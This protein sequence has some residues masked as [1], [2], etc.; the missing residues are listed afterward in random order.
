MVAEEE[1]ESNKSSKKDLTLD[2]IGTVLL[3]VLA[4]VGIVLVII[5]TFTIP[6]T[7]SELVGNVAIILIFLVLGAAYTI[8]VAGEAYREFKRTQEKSGERAVAPA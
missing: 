5:Q 3:D 8:V 2:V 1:N 4:L 7:A 6:H